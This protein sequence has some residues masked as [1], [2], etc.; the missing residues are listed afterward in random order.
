LPLQ[1]GSATVLRGRHIQQQLLLLNESQKI[2]KLRIQEKQRAA[3]KELNNALPIWHAQ[4]E[5]YIIN[6]PAKDPHSHGHVTLI[7]AT[8]SPSYQKIKKELKEE[9][10]NCRARIRIHK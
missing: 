7:R 6:T 10:P 9:T 1:K 2:F 4:L 8:I 3:I 5:G